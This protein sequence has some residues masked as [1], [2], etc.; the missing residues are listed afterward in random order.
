MMAFSKVP[1]VPETLHLERLARGLAGEWVQLPHSQG[2][3][4]W[5]EQKRQET[6]QTW[7][8]WG[9]GWLLCLAGELL[10]DLPN[11]QF[12]CLKPYES[13]LLSL[14]QSERVDGKHIDGKQVDVWQLMPTQGAVLLLWLGT[15]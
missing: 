14:D 1:E 2:R 7:G 13:Y 9:T 3:V 11:L 5:L 8:N 10:L 6:R 15:S 4:L 12:V